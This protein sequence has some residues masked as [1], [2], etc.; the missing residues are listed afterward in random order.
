MTD[1]ALNAAIAEEI[2]DRP[3]APSGDLDFCND[4]NVM[5]K[6][7]SLLTADEWTR[8]RSL[9]WEVA[10]GSSAREFE[11]ELRPQL[12]AHFTRGRAIQRRHSLSTRSGFLSFRDGHAC[13][14]PPLNPMNLLI[15]LAE[16]IQPEKT[17][18]WPDVVL[19]IFWAL[20]VL[21]LLGAFDRK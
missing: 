6:V 4:L 20:L 3:G 2:K 21:F 18:S 11:R 5:H 10:A 1:Q 19:E 13:R 9:L 17:T 15:L 8:Y 7:E 16:T 14:R 12:P